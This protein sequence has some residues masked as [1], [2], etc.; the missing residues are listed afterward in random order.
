MMSRTTGKWL[1]L[2]GGNPVRTEPPFSGYPAGLLI[3]A[4][5]PCEKSQSIHDETVVST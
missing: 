2:R 1:T 4:V 3:G 5:Q